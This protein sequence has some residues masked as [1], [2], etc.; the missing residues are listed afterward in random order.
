MF[1]A[2]P[3]LG[4]ESRRR[5]VRGSGQTRRIR[6]RV[7]HENAREAGRTGRDQRRPDPAAI[8]AC[9]RPSSSRRCAGSAR[10]GLRG[11]PGTA[12]PR[13]TTANQE[14]ETDEFAEN[15]VRYKYLRYFERPY[16]LRRRR[17]RGK[18]PDARAVRR[19]AS[20]DAQADPPPNDRRAAPR[21]RGASRDHLPR[22][23][24]PGRVHRDVDAADPPA[25]HRAGRGDVPGGRGGPTAGRRTQPPPFR[26]H[27]R[28]AIRPSES[29]S[30]RR[31]ASASS[32]RTAAAPTSSAT[33]PPSAAAATGRWTRRS[34][35]SSTSRRARR[36]RRRRTSARSEQRSHGGHGALRRGP[37][38]LLRTGV[39]C[40]QGP[41]DRAG[42][43][44]MS[45]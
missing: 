11:K 30:T 34:A 8:K 35:S 26:S 32:S 45:G 2:S 28:A 22:H 39:R 43:S 13:R 36:A 29:G 7:P 21:T 38:R 3:G 6:T 42:W 4:W 41:P 23:G 33:S 44:R 19:Q 24:P 14:P 18:N 15:G 16:S 20:D 31:R 12:R 17:K 25:A 37:R 10:A 1:T 9:Q 40:A 27:E 5:G